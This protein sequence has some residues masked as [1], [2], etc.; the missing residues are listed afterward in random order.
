MKKGHPENAV[1]KAIDLLVWTPSCFCCF[2]KSVYFCL[3]RSH[4]AITTFCVP[5][6]RLSLVSSDIKINARWWNAHEREAFVLL[7]GSRRLAMHSQ[8]CV[9]NILVQAW[10]AEH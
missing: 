6:S 3:F 10:A 9:Q 7:A 4:S 5:F 8:F 1:V 2:F